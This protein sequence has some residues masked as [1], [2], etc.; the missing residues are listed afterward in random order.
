[1]YCPRCGSKVE[2]TAKFCNRCG[3]SLNDNDQD[4]YDYTYKSTT[5]S[6][7]DLKKAYV[8][9]HYEKIQQTRFSVPTFFFGIYY[10]LYRKMWLYSFLWFVVTI[11]CSVLTFVYDVEYAALIL[12]AFIIAMTLGFSKLYL[13]TVD[14]RIQKIKQKNSNRSNQELLEECKR[15]G[16]VSVLAVVLSIIFIFIVSVCTVVGLLV[17][18]ITQEIDNSKT[19][20]DFNSSELNYEIPNIFEDKGYSSASYK[21]YS[22]YGNGDSCYLTISNYQTYGQ[23]SAED[24]L[25]T[26]VTSNMND[27]VSEILSKE[28]NGHVWKYVEVT[29]NDKTAYYYAYI[30]N[31]RIYQI[32]YTIYQ[33]NNNLCTKGYNNFINS[34]SFENINSGTDSI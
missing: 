18:V 7:E 32:K 9:D 10:L 4:K 33:D 25:K 15:K 11:I 3:S 23:R 20:K 28:I 31:S 24:Y 34:L 8:G 6:D 27:K 19:K 22:Y 12:L 14:K 21:N 1:M 17:G 29:S 16:G 13:S 2:D 26:D 30:Y 5:V